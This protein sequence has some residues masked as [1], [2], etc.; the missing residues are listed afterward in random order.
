MSFV[1]AFG[2]LPSGENSSSRA[3][4]E[5]QAAQTS[6]CHKESRNI[7]TGLRA[8]AESW[9]SQ[10]RP[11]WVLYPSRATGFK[12][13]GERLVVVPSVHPKPWPQMTTSGS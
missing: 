1:R 10:Q 2:Q 5:L 9:Y 7:A 12:A 13:A 6:G 3:P 8:A 4:I 11:E